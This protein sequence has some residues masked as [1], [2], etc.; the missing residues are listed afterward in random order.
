MHFITSIRPRVI[1][2]LL[3][4]LNIDKMT[5]TYTCQDTFCADTN[6]MAPFRNNETLLLSLP[7]TGFNED[8]Q[9]RTGDDPCRTMMEFCGRNVK[10]RCL[11]PMPTFVV[12]VDATFGLH[13][14]IQN[15]QSS[16][17][18]SCAV[19][20]T[21]KIKSLHIF[22]NIMRSASTFRENRNCTIIDMQSN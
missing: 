13:R 11:D 16:C 8:L 7:I 5:C 10:G 3:H 22:R 15:T 14:L 9:I 12:A 6:P 2:L 21:V 20:W 18:V 19:Q 17:S 1:W 4:V